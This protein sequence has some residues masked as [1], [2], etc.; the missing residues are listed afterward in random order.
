MA[1]AAAAGRP[2]GMLSIVGLTDDDIQQL[3]REVLYQLQERKDTICQLA[4]FL[5]PQ[6][7]VALQQ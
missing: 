1:A 5:F 3:C 4:N 6:V 7:G 2:H